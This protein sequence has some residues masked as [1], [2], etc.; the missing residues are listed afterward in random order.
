MREAF[1]RNAPSCSKEHA[2]MQLWQP[3]HLSGWII[4]IMLM[5]ACL[6]SP[7][8]NLGLSHYIQAAR[9]SAAAACE[10]FIVHTLVMCVQQ[11][12]DADQVGHACGGRW[13]GA[14]G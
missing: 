8:D 4:S 1:G 5:R 13:P 7:A 11:V 14:R 6:S 10:G 3:V 9:T 12:I 2:S